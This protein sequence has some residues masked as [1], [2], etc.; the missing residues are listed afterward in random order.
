MIQIIMPVFNEE[1]GVLESVRTVH[2]TAAAASI[3]HGFLLVD[4][5]SRDRT[6]EKLNE[7]ADEI[8]QVTLL[9]FSR[10]FGKEAA[11]SAALEHADADAVVVMDADLQHPPEL[12][13]EMV[14]LWREEGYDVVDGV[15][16]SRGQESALHRACAT[17]YY[18]IF[19]RASGGKT[20][21]LS[22]YKLMD[23]RAVEAWRKLGERNPFFRGMS[24]WVGF[25]HCSVPFEV[26]PR[27][28]GD[29]KWPLRSLVR[30]AA[31]SVTAYTSAPLLLPLIPGGASL[32]LFLVLGLRA[33]CL[34]LAGRAPGAAAGLAL[35]AL[36]LGGWILI[37]L[38]ILGLYLGK[39]YEEAKK[40]PRYLISQTR[41]PGED[42]GRHG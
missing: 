13:P 1:D 16:T 7:L 12:I 31:N 24:A 11:L 42:G 14:R 22:D 27:R 18:R 39:I 15:K 5:G 8:P 34:L 19:S 40:R 21:Q 6:W 35:L 23:R 10:N 25:R 37:S 17:L 32:L 36:F 20:D 41:K 3:E 30:L 28:T 33:L 2:A 29:S 4:D 9:R 26:A 38:G